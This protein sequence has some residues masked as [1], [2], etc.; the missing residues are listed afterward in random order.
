MI[1]VTSG[2]YVFQFDVSKLDPSGLNWA[3]GYRDISTLREYPHHPCCGG[4]RQ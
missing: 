1:Y 3:A 4:S 2:F